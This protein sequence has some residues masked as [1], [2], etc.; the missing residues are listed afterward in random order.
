MNSLRPNLNLQRRSQ[1]PGTK[2]HLKKSKFRS[3]HKF[4]QRRTPEPRARC[5][6]ISNHPR[7]RNQNQLFKQ[8][9]SKSVLPMP[10]ETP[11][12]QLKRTLTAEPNKRNQGHRRR[13]AAL[14]G[15]RPR[16]KRCRGISK[17]CQLPPSTKSSSA[18]MWQKP[19]FW[20]SLWLLSF[21]FSTVAS[22][23]RELPQDS[24]CTAADFL[25]RRR[26]L[27]PHPNKRMDDVIRI[28]APPHN[29]SILVNV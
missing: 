22:P 23:E 8:V 2:L 29:V 26:N 18:S 6:G 14:S 15:S 24:K 9:E 28:D 25:I 19:P 7:N 16:Q 13:I 3:L 11:Q 10:T 1:N 17:R 5:P 4:Q 12:Q 21:G 20:P 27:L